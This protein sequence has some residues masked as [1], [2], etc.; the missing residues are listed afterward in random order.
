M[1]VIAVNKFYYMQGGSERYYFELNRLLREKGIEVIPFSMKDERNVS[2]DYSEFFVSNLNLQGKLSFKQKLSL[3]VRVVY[4]RE[5]KKNFTALIEKVKPDIIHLHNIAHHISPS[6]IPV[7]KKKGIP[8]VQTLHDFKLLCPSYLFIN[9]GES[10]ELCAN[11]N[12]LHAVSSKCVKG[13]YF[14]SLILAAEM[15]VHRNSG[16]Y[17]LADRFICPSRFMIDKFKSYG[18]IRDDKLAYIP[19]FVSVEDF[20]PSK[21]YSDYY[22]YFGRLSAEKGVD[23]LINSVDPTWKERLLIAGDGLERKKL[24]EIK[25]EKNLSNVEFLGNKSGDELKGII[26]NSIFTIIPSRCYDNSPLALFESFACGKAVIGSRI[27]GIPELIDEGKDGLLFE[28]QN[29]NVLREKIKYLLDHKE[30]AVSYGMAGRNK[31]EKRFN[32]DLHIERI[33]SLYNSLM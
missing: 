20:K 32:S 5:A 16:I 17:N 27:G 1:K 33:I 11:G 18:I 25:K 10:C 4:S 6:I 29:S 23:V 15:F 24:E 8:V 13:S 9:N 22:L 21:E 12:F 7:A 19:N 28:S 2:S 14:G 26:R 30:L 3:P 31:V